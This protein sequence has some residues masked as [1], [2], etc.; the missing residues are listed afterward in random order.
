MFKKL[1]LV[2][3]CS[4]LTVSAPIITR[5]AQCPSPT[6]NFGNSPTPVTRLNEINMIYALVK[7][8]A[9]LTGYP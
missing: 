7:N 1:L 6:D 2:T 3:L 4:M 9:V 5:S 8:A